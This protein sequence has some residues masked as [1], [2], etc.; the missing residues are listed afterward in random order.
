VIGGNRRAPPA[1][2]LATSDAIFYKPPENSS[3]EIAS[4]EKGMAQAGSE[5]HSRRLRRKQKHE[6]R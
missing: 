5:E 4:V 2:S 6:L 1:F 3:E